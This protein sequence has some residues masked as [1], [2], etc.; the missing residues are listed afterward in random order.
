MRSYDLDHRVPSEFCKIVY[1]DDRIVVAT[2][3]IV[4]ARFKLNKIGDMRGIIS[5]PFHL[6]DNATKPK[7]FSYG[8]T[9]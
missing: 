4:H 2:P 1:A 7:S 5:R 3:Y 6:A 8:A 9:G